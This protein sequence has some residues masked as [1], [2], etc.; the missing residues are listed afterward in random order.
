[1]GRSFDELHSSIAEVD[2]MGS[3]ATPIKRAERRQITQVELIKVSSKQI[4]LW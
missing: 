3:M 2:V 1:M 4:F